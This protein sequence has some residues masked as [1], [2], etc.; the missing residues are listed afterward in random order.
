MKKLLAT[1]LMLFYLIPA[2][3]V[4]VSVHFCG[5]KA[6]SL[7][8]SAIKKN[9]CVCSWGTH[10]KSCCEDRHH[11]LKIDD[12]QQKS[13]LLIHKFSNPFHV[14]YTAPWVYKTLTQVLASPVSIPKLVAPPCLYRNSIYILNRVLRI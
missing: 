6:A 3:G 1:L 9:K 13:E 7:E 2:I 10:K 4:N 12:T 8:Y 14:L 5:G 11:I